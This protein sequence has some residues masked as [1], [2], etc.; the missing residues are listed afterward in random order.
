[1]G[2]EAM[3]KYMTAKEAS[4]EF[5]CTPEHIQKLMKEMREYI[6]ERYGKLTFFGEGRAIAVRTV[7]LIDYSAHRQ[8]IRD[9]NG[10]I[11]NFNA[12][13]SERELGIGEHEHGNNEDRSNRC[14]VWECPFRRF[15]RGTG[16][17]SDPRHEDGQ[18]GTV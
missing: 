10:N 7:C 5:G 2:Y 17:V 16:R 18:V 4:V 13:E 3:K 15:E 9:G 11:V 6:P 8:L 14:I 12:V 1:M